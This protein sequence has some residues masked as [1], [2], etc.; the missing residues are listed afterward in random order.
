[1]EIRTVKA[2]AAVG[3]YRIARFVQLKGVVVIRIARRVVLR[4]VG[5]GGLPFFGF[6]AAL[7]ILGAIQRHSPMPEIIHLVHRHSFAACRADLIRCGCAVQADFD[8]RA[9]RR[10]FRSR[11]PILFDGELGGSHVDERE[12][13]IGGIS[14][15]DIN[16]ILRWQLHIV[17]LGRNLNHLEVLHR[18]AVN[19]C[20]QLFPRVRPVRPLQSHF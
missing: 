6:K 10:G 4:Q 9:I 19:L 3:R 18:F 20:G 5:E 8:R 17:A 11:V 7:S 12:G 13:D 14:F 2:D 1:M 16:F 15:P